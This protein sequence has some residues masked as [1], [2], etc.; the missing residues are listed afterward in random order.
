MCVRV[1]VHVYVC[2]CVWDGSCENALI[3]K[4]LT[5]EVLV[6]TLM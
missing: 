5:E 3:T 1:G 2:V 6:T 4:L